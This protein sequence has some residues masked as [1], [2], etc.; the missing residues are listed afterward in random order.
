MTQRRPLALIILDGFGLSKFPDGDATK[1]AKTPTIDWLYTNCPH[2]TLNASGE[3]V[4][5]MDG[6]MG[7]SNVGHLNIGAGR[8][9]YQDIARIYKAIK[10]GEF[11][12]NPELVAAMT[13]AKENNSAL[14]L[15]G[16]VSPGG[17][18]SH[19]DHLYALLEMAK[20]FG[21]DKVYVHAFLDGRDVPPKSAI[22]YL[23]NLEA[24]IAEIGVGQI[25]TVTGR[26]YA[27]DRDKRWERVEKA[28]RALVL[29]E[30]E[31]ASTA[32]EAVENAYQRGETD[33][34]VL[35]TVVRKDNLPVAT[36]QN[37][38][39][40]IFF[41][42]RAD[43]ARQLSWAFT[44]EEFEGFTRP[45]GKLDLYFV[46]MTQYDST[47]QAPVAFGPQDLNNT[48]GEYVSA[49][50]LKQLRI[51]ET[52]KFYHV[53]FFFNGGVDEQF[54]GEDRKLIP[55]PKVATYDLKPEMSA[56]EVTDAVVEAINSSNYDL[57]VLNY[58]NCDMVGHTGVMEAAVTAVEAV[59]TGL[60]K[61]LEAL[62]ANDWQA[63]IT[64]DHGN[65]EQMVDPES[66]GIHTAHTTN[67]VPIWLFNTPGKR[68]KEG[69]LADI[70]PSV[71]DLLGLEKPEEMEGTSLIIKEEE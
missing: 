28:Y 34:F 53:T 54:E 33:E 3:A 47:I 67:P 6:Q 13:K 70:A 23:E 1:K 58:A 37:K 49:A 46:C 41:N 26:Y 10:S 4:G 16:L 71:L 25:A 9:V 57:I 11:A 48:L 63:I 20:Q 21:L 14:H 44:S 32:V 65:A 17:V 8:I 35:P 12:L 51:A 15:M 19:T 61:V 55:S 60:G 22:E 56:Y 50:G 2:A 30:G 7:D 62:K 43:R 39:S 29:G 68:I 69:I 5:L 52:E 18:H 36:V 59:D 45:G 38:D 64:A 42:F 27:M 66:N 31:T 40:V 24:K